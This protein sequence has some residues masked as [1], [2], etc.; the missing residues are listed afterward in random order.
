LGAFEH[1]LSRAGYSPLHEDEYDQLRL[2]VVTEGL[3]RVEQGF[4]RLTS[5]SFETSVPAG[6]ESV[7]YEINLAGCEHLKIATSSAESPTIWPN[8]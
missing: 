7:E 8:V 6:V 3:Y 2:R 4:P 5:D 1:T